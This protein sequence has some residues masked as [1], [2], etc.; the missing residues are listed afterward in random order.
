MPRPTTLQSTRYLFHSS[1]RLEHGTGVSAGASE[2]IPVRHGMFSANCLHQCPS[3][4]Q[5]I[6]IATN[7]MA[8]IVG[9][10]YHSVR[11]SFTDSKVPCQR[12]E[13]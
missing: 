13:A 9:V 11:L 6:K 3:H 7:E 1:L 2:C 10:H 12:E 5:L 8:I 4:P